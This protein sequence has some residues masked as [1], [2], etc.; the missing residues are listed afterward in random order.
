MSNKKND[1]TS[2]FQQELDAEL[3]KSERRRTVILIGL[4]TF[5]IAY[6]VIDMYVFKQDALTESAQSF[7]TTWMF[8][9]AVLV[10]ES[11]SF[12]YI[13]RRLRSDNKHIPLVAQYMNVLFEICLPS[14][15]I[16]FVARQH[17]D[18][19][20]LQSPAV[21]IYFVFII[22]ST[23]RLNFGLSFT[24]GL[25]AAVWCLAFA[26][27][28]NHFYSTDAA[29]CMVIL[30]SG[31]AAGLVGMQIRKGI[32]N[33]AFVA[34]RQQQIANLFGQQVSKEVAEK[35]LENDG[36]I[37]SSRMNVAVMFIDIRNFSA[38]VADKRPEEIVQYQ[39]SFFSIV[40]DSIETHKGIVNQFLGDGCMITFGAPLALDNPSRNAVEAA[41]EI[42]GSLETRIGEGKIAP[43]RIGIGIH[44][45]EAVTGNIGTLH[46][47]QYSITGNVVILATRIEQLNKEFHSQVL[48]SEDVYQSVGQ[49]HSTAQRFADVLMKGWHRPMNVYKLA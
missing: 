9:I 29:R 46:R 26:L 48:V 37:E 23:L 16:L 40:I 42:L 45:G 17:P 31:T 44:T 7:S 33:S 32:N 3:L 1:M 15:I 8:P 21:Y 11:L 19:D 27:M 35:M 22:L 14:L 38:Y 5:A 47:Q 24:C 20:V 10:F 13:T 34:E 39:N 18:F 49:Q 43:T 41:M 6:R 2:I 28:K 25:L 30:L 4:F 36:K 12:L